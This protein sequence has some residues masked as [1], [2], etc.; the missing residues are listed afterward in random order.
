M[1]ERERES[2]R[3]C[4]C[5]RKRARESVSVRQRGM[6]VRSGKSDTT[7]MIPHLRE[8][9]CLSVCEREREGESE[10]RTPGWA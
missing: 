1:C 7:P 2:E 5:E 8:K 4:V 6:S 10:R 9:V 3:E